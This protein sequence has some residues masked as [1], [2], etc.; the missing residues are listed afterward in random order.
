MK[1]FLFPLLAALALPTAV[2]SAPITKYEVKTDPLTDEKKVNIMLLS[3][4][5]TDNS[6]G[7]PRFTSLFIF[8]TAGQPEV[9]ILTPSFNS[10]NREVALRWNKE[11][12]VYEK[13]NINQKKTGFFPPDTRE[14]IS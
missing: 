13:W 11:K 7:T 8:C 5:K 12:P 9:F 1:R 6:I 10:D 14:I 2:S 3:D 4:D